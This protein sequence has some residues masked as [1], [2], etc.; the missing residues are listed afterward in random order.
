MLVRE[1]WEIVN[2]LGQYGLFVKS[3]LENI[4]DDS[5]ICKSG[6]QRCD[7]YSNNPGCKISG[8]IEEARI[9]HAVFGRFYE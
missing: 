3:R 2:L 9:I 6:C 8:I 1:N 7:F 5:I 4:D